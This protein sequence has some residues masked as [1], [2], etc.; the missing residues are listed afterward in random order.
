MN[1]NGKLLAGIMGGTILSASNFPP[2]TDMLHTAILAAVGAA[3]S[4]LTAWLLQY[5]VRRRRR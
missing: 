4:F 2:W 3:V 1:S 5:F